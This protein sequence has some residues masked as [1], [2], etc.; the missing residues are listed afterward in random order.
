MG[1]PTGSLT[2]R[3]ECTGVATSKLLEKRPSY[4]IVRQLL[5]ATLN[6]VREVVVCL[7]FSAIF[8]CHGQVFHRDGSRGTPLGSNSNADID[9]VVGFIASGCVILHQKVL[10]GTARAIDPAAATSTSALDITK[11]GENDQ[12]LLVSLNKFIDIYVYSRMYVCVCKRGRHHFLLSVE[13]ERGQRA[14]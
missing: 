9:I 1:L 8:D 3:A 4:L 5:V 2:I 12:S 7:W 11:S 13:H 10:N 14:R 6:N